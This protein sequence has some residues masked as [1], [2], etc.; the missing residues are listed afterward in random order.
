M[1]NRKQDEERNRSEH[2]KH[3]VTVENTREWSEHDHRCAHATDSAITSTSGNGHHKDL[4]H[5]L[6]QPPPLVAPCQASKPGP[7]RERS[8]QR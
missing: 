6:H 8:S 4:K 7:R 1:N 3:T 2:T 5:P